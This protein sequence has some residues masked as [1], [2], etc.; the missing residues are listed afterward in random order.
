MSESRRIGFVGL[1]HMGAPMAANLVRGGHH[2]MGYDIVAD[3]AR[4][5]AQTH[6]TRMPE[7]LAEVGMH[8]DIVITMLPTG[9]EVRDALLEAQ[10]GALAANLRRGAVVVDMSSAEPVGTRMLGRDLARRGIALV[11]A[12][13]SPAGCRAP[14]TVPSPS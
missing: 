5:F 12:N 8:A 7:S 2:V 10:G 9:R 13:P 11:D 3:Q 1:G 6:G 14:R 4:R